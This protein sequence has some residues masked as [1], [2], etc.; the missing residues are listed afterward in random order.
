MRIRERPTL[1]RDADALTLE[2]GMKPRKPRI[3]L[4]D[5]KEVLALGG[6]MTLAVL[7]A[8]TLG[9]HL[10]KRVG[11]KG[12]EIQ[13]QEIPLTRAV[14]DAVPNRVELAEQG[15]GSEVAA[16]EALTEELEHEVKK[17]ELRVDA[18]RQVD[19][20]ER[21]KR[22]NAG[23]TQVSQTAKEEGA[24]EPPRE[25]GDAPKGR[26]H[27]PQFTLQIGS[28][29]AVEE[30]KTQLQSFESQGLKAF[31]KEAEVRGK[32]KRYRVYVGAFDSKNAA[33]KA[34]ADYQA[35]KLIETFVISPVPH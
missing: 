25:E 7:F 30:A 9:L 21:A 6:V 29:P 31:L 33:A 28:Y 1:T 2:A 10:G 24:K 18:A 5:R 19:L 14:P 32:G 15:K 22:K 17:L 11:P 23:A 26:L 12:M 35:K 16:D 3:Y 34:G 4:F 13:I 27:H 20:P 8:F